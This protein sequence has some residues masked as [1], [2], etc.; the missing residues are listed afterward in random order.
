MPLFT[1]KWKNEGKAVRWD[2]NLSPLML[3]TWLGGGRASRE[4]GRTQK[5][6]EPERDLENQ[7]TLTS[8]EGPWT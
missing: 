7:E 4:E 8:K 5:V 2:S 3:H 1:L 6:G